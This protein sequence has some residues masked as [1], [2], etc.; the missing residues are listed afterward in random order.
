MESPK[1]SPAPIKPPKLWRYAVGFLVLAILWVLVLELW[2]RPRVLSMGGRIGFR[3]AIY[4]ILPMVLVSSAYILRCRSCVKRRQRQEE[5]EFEARIQADLERERAEAEAAAVLAEKQFVLEVLAVGLSVEH[6]KQAEVWEEVQAVEEPG[7]VLSQDPEGLPSDPGGKMRQA[8]E[9][10][11]E[12]LGRVLGWINKEWSI[13]TF[14]ALPELLN[15]QMADLPE[16]NLVEAAM[17]AGLPAD[18][19]N[20]VESFFAQSPAEVVGNV[21][22]FMERNPEVPAV[23][24]IAEDSAS[25]RDCLRPDGAPSELRDGPRRPGE[26]VGSIVAMVLG[27]RE[28]VDSMRELVRVGDS[29]YE[30]MTPFWDRED[31][32]RASAPFVATSWLPRPWSRGLLER[33]DHLRVLGSLHRPESVSLIGEDGA[34]GPASQASAFVEGWKNLME[35]RHRAEPLANLLYEHGPVVWGRRLSPMDRAFQ[36][37]EPDWDTFEQGINLHRYLGDLGGNAPYVGLAMGVVASFREGG[38]S[39][40]VDL[41]RDECASLLMVTEPPERGGEDEDP[42]SAEFSHEAA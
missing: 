34:L 20:V 2:I 32:K 24:L 26:P 29:S 36:E 4:L 17:H 6:L 30:A 12:A 19:L 39:I 35:R 10:Q 18:A 9:R 25:L 13:P 23:C 31:A 38:M 33:F 11:V 40:C 1:P 41:R 8:R 15:A 22:D 7:L 28:R 5:A 42:L 3:L 37:V 27:R 14:I 21:F 16:S